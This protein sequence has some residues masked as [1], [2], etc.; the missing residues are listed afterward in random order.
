[1]CVQT[2]RGQD[3]LDFSFDVRDILRKDTYVGSTR[4]SNR[5]KVPLLFCIKTIT[6]VFLNFSMNYNHWTTITDALL[7]QATAV[8][9]S[10]SQPCGGTT[11]PVRRPTYSWR[12]ES[13]QIVIVVI[14]MTKRRC[15][16][17]LSGKKIV[18][19]DHCD[20]NLPQVTVVGSGLRAVTKEH[21]L[22]EYW[23][24]RF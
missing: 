11:Y 9:T 16:D 14:M 18:I 8:W 24:N 10:L 2:G 4:Q 20:R 3:G 12:W 7:L 17:N 1:M 5:L 13:R 22:T 6:N 23:A 15:L 21:G 19:F